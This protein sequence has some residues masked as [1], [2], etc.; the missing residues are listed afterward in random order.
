[1]NVRE[2]PIV[3][4]F[5]TYQDRRIEDNKLFFGDFKKCR[6][7]F[8]KLISTLCKQIEYLHQRA[9]LMMTGVELSTPHTEN[10]LCSICAEMLHIIAEFGKTATDI[11]KRYYDLMQ[12]IPSDIVQNQ[13]NGENISDKILILD[14][15]D[16][17][18]HHSSHIED[19]IVISDDEKCEDDDDDEECQKAKQNSDS[20]DC[21]IYYTF[22]DQDV[23]TMEGIIQIVE[24]FPQDDENESKI[25][26]KI[27]KSEKH[28]INDATRIKSTFMTR[29]EQGVFFKQKVSHCEVFV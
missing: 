4:P 2:K 17:N 15:D 16:Q 14:N 13:S 20:S 18:S 6:C 19:T 26:A 22:D 27:K 5:K 9:F 3:N 21:E 7:C 28:T 1:M 8:S 12:D 23:K 11:Q 29:T 10:F 25:D 24:E